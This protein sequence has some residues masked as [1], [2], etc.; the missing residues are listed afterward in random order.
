MCK[1]LKLLFLLLASWNASAALI[2][3]DVSQQS[4]NTYVAE[5]K[6][7]NDGTTPIEA[8]T[9][10]FEFGLFQNIS[11]INTPA[12]WDFFAADPDDFFGAIEPGLVDGV[13]FSTPLEVGDMLSGLTVS[14]EWLGAAG[15]LSFN[16]AFEIYDANNFDV[17]QSGNFEVV[18]QVVSEPAYLSLLIMGFGLCLVS[19]KKSHQGAV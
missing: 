3:A 16:Q 12:D 15:N 10:F 1:R 17:L 19:R 7:T 5:Y 14:F 6:I 11:L 18:S 9:L 2:E 8:F 4:N 13:T